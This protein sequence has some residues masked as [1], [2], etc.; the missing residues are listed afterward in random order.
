MHDGSFEFL[1][2]LPGRNTGLGLVAVTDGDLVVLY[3]GD[4]AALLELDQ[5]V[6]VGF[7]PAYLP[8][9]RFKDAGERP[10]SVFTMR[11]KTSIGVPE[12]C[13]LHVF[14]KVKVLRIVFHVLLELTRNH[15]NWILYVKNTTS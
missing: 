4:H 5:P 6:C 12:R 3:R 2:A 13:A 11:Q 14:Q 15:I 1:L 9:C 8:Y 7:V 10:L